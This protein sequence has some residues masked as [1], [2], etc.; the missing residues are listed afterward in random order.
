MTCPT[1][2][3]PHSARFRF[4]RSTYAKRRT[5]AA[6]RSESPPLEVCTPLP[7]AGDDGL[8]FRL[9]CRHPSSPSP[10][11][12]EEQTRGLQ[13]RENP[14]KVCKPSL[15][16]KALAPLGFTAPLYI[17]YR[18]LDSKTQLAV[19]NRKERETFALSAAQG[20]QKGISLPF[21]FHLRSS[22]PTLCTHGPLF[23]FLHLLTSGFYR[24]APANRRHRPPKPGS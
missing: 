6:R 23:S 24:V 15:R 3:G 5:I 10:I 22:I 4:Q 8:I 18:P 14:V 13:Q 17:P 7:A 19:Q 21:R 1:P 2:R 9:F 11:M 20:V 16:R 12:N